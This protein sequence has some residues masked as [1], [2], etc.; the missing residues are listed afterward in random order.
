MST[1]VKPSERVSILAT[2]DPASLTAAAH[3]SDWVDS[4]QFHRF[5]SII[6]TGTL[7]ASATV[8]AKLQQATDSSGTGAKDITGKSITQLVKASNDN[9]QV[10]IDL[11]PEELDQT[12]GFQYFALV[13]TVGTAAS[14]ADGTILG[15]DPRQGLGTD[16][17]LASVVQNV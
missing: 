12:N 2:V 4:A 8:D 1:N 13:I 9:D 5:L 7:G 10:T 17:N 6:K 3:T 14:E 11:R 16:F 15:F